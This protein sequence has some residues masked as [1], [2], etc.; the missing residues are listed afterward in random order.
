MTRRRLIWVLGWVTALATSVP[1]AMAQ[2]PSPQKV[3]SDAFANLDKVMGEH[4]DDPASSRW[5]PLGG[6]MVLAPRSGGRIQ[7][8]G[9]TEKGS[10]RPAYGLAS[11][12]LQGACKDTGRTDRYKVGGTWF[13]FKVL[14]VGGKRVLSPQ[15]V[16]GKN[17]LYA[18]VRNGGNLTIESGKGWTVDFDLQGAPF[19]DAV[20]SVRAADAAMPERPKTAHPAPP[21]L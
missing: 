20:L 13:S 18:V 10:T 11:D 9:W 16:A 14:C 21:V 6:L 7:L 3:M 8:V 1:Q 19:A 4:A 5:T 17:G 12:N 15:S 2:N